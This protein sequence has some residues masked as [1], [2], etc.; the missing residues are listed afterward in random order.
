M[1]NSSKLLNFDLNRQLEFSVFRGVGFSSQ[2]DLHFDLN[3]SLSF[4]SQRILPF[5]KKGV[6]FRQFVCGRCGVI[7]DGEAERCP[8]CKARFLSDEEPIESS[9]LVKSSKKVTHSKMEEY[10]GEE[11]VEEVKPPPIRRA[12]VYRCP[13]CGKNLRY[14]PPQKKWYCSR[15]KIYIGTTP[16]GRPKPVRAY[17]PRAGAASGG[18]KFIVEQRGSR[19]PSE[20]VIVEELNRRKRGR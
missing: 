5:G 14:I 12:P 6:D 20:V 9:T 2:R 10:F 17:T 15:C 8:N 18:V 11:Y 13:S 16:R 1:K 19:R 7:V 3:R 4:D